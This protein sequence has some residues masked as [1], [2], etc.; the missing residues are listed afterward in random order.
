MVRT[1][2][3]PDP[4]GITKVAFEVTFSI[5]RSEFGMK[6]MDMVSDEVALIGGLEWNRVPASE[7]TRAAAP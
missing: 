3:R 6:G 5:K 1:G 4:G 7:G 2:V